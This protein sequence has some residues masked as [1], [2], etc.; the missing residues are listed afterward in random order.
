MNYCFPA[1]LLK[2]CKSAYD[3]NDCLVC[4]DNYARVI[5]PS[6]KEADSFVAQCVNM[7]VPN[8]T[9]V[10]SINSINSTVPLCKTCTQGYFWN[11]TSLKCEKGNVI[12]C[13]E[14]TSNNI[15]QCTKCATGYALFANTTGI[16]HC[17]P[18][19]NSS[20]MNCSAMTV[21]ILNTTGPISQ[22][23]FK[24]TDDTCTN[25]NYSMRTQTTLIASY[26]VCSKFSSTTNCSTYTYV[27]D[28]IQP[29]TTV[30]ECATCLTNYYHN[31]DTTNSNAKTCKK[32]FISQSNCLTQSATSDE[33]T[34][35]GCS[36]GFYLTSGNYCAANPKGTYKCAIYD[37]LGETCTTC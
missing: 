27:S 31:T 33:C 32:R 29:I 9:V 37:S 5:I 25:G 23:A 21:D 35:L 8:C 20:I 15:N 14:Y 19:Y 4:E 1:E 17:F 22:L 30:P 2:N 16:S 34:S 26:F 36:S 10:D 6:E 7:T 11:T 3:Y 12:N 24:C 18:N 13:L 28:G